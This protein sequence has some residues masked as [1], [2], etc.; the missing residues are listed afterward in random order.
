M[1]GSEG[2]VSRSLEIVSEEHCIFH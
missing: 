2:E 1:L